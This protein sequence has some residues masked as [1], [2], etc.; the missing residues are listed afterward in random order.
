MMINLGNCTPALLK[1]FDHHVKRERKCW[2]AP[3]AVWCVLSVLRLFRMIEA[4]QFHTVSSVEDE[5]QCIL[6]SKLRCATNWVIWRFLGFVF[7]GN[8]SCQVCISRNGIYPK[9][10]FQVIGKFSG[11]L[12]DS[13]LFAD[14][15]VI[16]MVIG[17]ILETRIVFLCPFVLS[18]VDNLL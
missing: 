12:L 4:L 13:L 7:S 17:Q 16:F 3:K 1:T 2:L 14:T 18:P 15:C 5:E 10:I 6:F 11:K 8:N 9:Y